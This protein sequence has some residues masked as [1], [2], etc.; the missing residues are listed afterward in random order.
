V[1]CS[2]VN[3]TFTF[4]IELRMQ[5]VRCDE[6]NVTRVNVPGTRDGND[7]QRVNVFAFTQRKESNA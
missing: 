7:C 6:V 2:R 4:S 1:A 5:V 3:F